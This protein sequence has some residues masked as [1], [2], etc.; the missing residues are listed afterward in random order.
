MSLF[1]SHYVLVDVSLIQPFACSNSAQ[2][3]QSCSDVVVLSLTTQVPQQVPDGLS[4]V[5]IDLK[6]CVRVSV[7]VT[8]V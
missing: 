5:W 4:G 3:C 8:A 2:W 7:F 6:L 1:A